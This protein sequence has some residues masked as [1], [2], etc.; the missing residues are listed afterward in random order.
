MTK[1]FICKFVNDIRLS[2]LSIH[3]LPILIL[4]AFPS[5]AAFIFNR[6]YFFVLNRSIISYYHCCIECC[7]FYKSGY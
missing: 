7:Q 4:L 6:L 1:I 3:S 5:S 2:Y